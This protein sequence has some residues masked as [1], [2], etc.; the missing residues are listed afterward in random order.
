[1]VSPRPL[2]ILAPHSPECVKVISAK[3]RKGRGISPASA[4]RSKALALGVVGPYLAVDLL[5]EGLAVL[6]LLLELAHLLKLLR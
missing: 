2:L 5:E 4:S 3:Q 6:I 1:M